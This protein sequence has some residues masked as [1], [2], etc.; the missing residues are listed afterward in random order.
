MVLRMVLKMTLLK[1]NQYITSHPDSKIYFSRLKPLS[2]VYQMHHRHNLR[3]E[4]L[5]RLYLAVRTW[6]M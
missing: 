1:T 6:W 4:C 3:R 2:D 5:L